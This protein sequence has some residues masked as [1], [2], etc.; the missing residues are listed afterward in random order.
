MA[1]KEDLVAEL[2]EDSLVSAWLSRSA[3]FDDL[4]AYGTLEESAACVAAYCTNCNKFLQIFDEI[5]IIEL[6]LRGGQRNP[7]LNALVVT[8]IEGKPEV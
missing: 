7:S 2:R 4:P 8:S 5:P 6:L 1:A 3:I